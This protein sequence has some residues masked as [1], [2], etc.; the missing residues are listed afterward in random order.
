MKLH[1]LLPKLILEKEHNLRHARTIEASRKR[2][3]RP[4][5]DQIK[6]IINYLTVVYMEGRSLK[7]EAKGKGIQCKFTCYH[8]IIWQL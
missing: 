4:L 3:I 7:G 6:I 8:K 2:I 1:L 5:N